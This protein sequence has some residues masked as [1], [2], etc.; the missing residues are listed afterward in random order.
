MILLDGQ[1]LAKSKELELKDKVSNLDSVPSLV[2]IQV[3][4]NSAS[5]SYIR[6]K[7]K[8]GSRIGVQVL[9]HKF[10][11]DISEDI[12]LEAINY[13]N[14]DISVGGIIVQLPLP[15]HINKNK[16]INQIKDSKDVDGLGLINGGK[17][18]KEDFTAKLP[19]TPKGIVT[20]LKDYNIKIEGQNVVIVGRSK[21]VGLP[22]FILLVH[23]N[24]TV[25]L[26][27][28]HTKNLADITSKA[29]IL[30]SACGKPNFITSEYVKNDAVVID[31]GSTFI[32]SKITGDVDFNA[33]FDKVKAITPV[34]GGVGPMTV[35]SLFDNLL[36][37]L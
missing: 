20:L 30:I 14:Q 12:L 23:E 2:V 18:L 22:L 15:N 37:S 26:T 32:D 17:L 6:V 29:D 11:E 1:K 16:L 35:Y 25:T 31:V 13:C 21:L 3:G 5:N 34:P 9:I 10:S 19:A 33:V 24:A 28:S 8:F 7:K 27:H 36:E 4:D